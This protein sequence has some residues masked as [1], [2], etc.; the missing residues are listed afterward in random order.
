MEENLIHPS[1]MISDL[2][3]IYPD[4]V[5]EMDVTWQM[6]MAVFRAKNFI[7]KT[8]RNTWDKSGN[9]NFGFSKANLRCFNCHNPGHFA[10]ECNEPKVDL[11]DGDKHIVLLMVLN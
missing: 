5:E 8:G 10:K 6:A 3:Q 11:V 1:V 4:D 2:D 9:R 7:K